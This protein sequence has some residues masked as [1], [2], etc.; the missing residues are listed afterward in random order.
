MYNKL[1]DLATE[2]SKNEL[3]KHISKEKTIKEKEK[4]V[5]LLHAYT[6]GYSYIEGI[7]CKALPVVLCSRHQ[8][9]LFNLL[10]C[11]SS[12]DAA[13]AFFSGI[14]SCPLSLSN[15]NIPV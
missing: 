15:Q 11:L 9:N 5:F 3:D 6:R 14:L 2:A 10:S 8:N 12:Q 4:A 13:Y 1:F 7:Y